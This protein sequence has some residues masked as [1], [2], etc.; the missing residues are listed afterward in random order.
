MNNQDKATAMHKDLSRLKRIA[1]AKKKEKAIARMLWTIAITATVFVPFVALTSITK[2]V[3]ASQAKIQIVK[4]PTPVN[5][6]VLNTKPLILTETLWKTKT[7]I[8]Y[9]TK[10]AKKPRNFAVAA[11]KKES[12]MKVAGLYEKDFVG[13][14][15]IPPIDRLPRPYH[16]IDKNHERIACKTKPVSEKEFLEMKENKKSVFNECVFF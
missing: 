13:G 11:R 5:S 2:P 6:L 14:E 7:V 10:V 9:R 12:S 16:M 8:K 3:E 1:K 4:V 15:Y